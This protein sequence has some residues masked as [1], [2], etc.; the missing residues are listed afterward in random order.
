MEA[1]YGDLKAV[2]VD[3]AIIEPAPHVAA[4]EGDLNWGDIGSWAALTDVLDVDEAAAPGDAPAPAEPA[5]PRI[6]QRSRASTEEPTSCV[7]PR[8]KRPCSSVVFRAKR[9]TAWRPCLRR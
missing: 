8:S 5:A 1:E 7:T 9:K 3:N 2:A 6:P 4:L